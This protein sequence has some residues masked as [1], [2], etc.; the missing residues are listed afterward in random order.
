MKFTLGEMIFDSKKQARDFVSN[1]LKTNHKI[2]SGDIN[3]VEDLL[4]RH[5]RWEDKSENYKTITIE[6]IG[7]NRAF[8]LVKNDDSLEDISYIKC[9]YGETEHMLV[10][11]TLRNEISDQIVSFRRNCFSA[12]SEIKCEICETILK[13]D[14]STHVDHIIMFKDL[15]QSFRKQHQNIPTKSIGTEREIS[16]TVISNEWKEYHKQYAKLRLLCDKCNMSR[17]AGD[18]REPE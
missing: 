7:A 17:Q 14:L 18:S 1:Y 13:N 11:K 6:K 9:F 4:S 16:D 15:V 5:P 12:H 8:F 3:W 2:E 10:N